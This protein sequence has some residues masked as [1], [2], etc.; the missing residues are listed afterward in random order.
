MQLTLN[1][2]VRWSLA[3]SKSGSY[4]RGQCAGMTIGAAMGCRENDAESMERQ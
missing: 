4:K 3:L 1:L 2:L